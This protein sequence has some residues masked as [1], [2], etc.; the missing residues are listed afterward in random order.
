VWGL[1]YFD[2]STGESVLLA[3]VKESEG[4]LVGDNVV[5]YP[6]AFTDLSADIRYTYTR[7]GFEQDVVFRNNPPAPTE[8]GLN[9]ET[10]RLQVLTEFV[11]AGTPTK[12]RQQLGQL[13]DDTLGFSGLTIGPG[14][15]F[16]VPAG[17][18]GQER[19]VAKQWEQL[20]GRD[21]LIEELP[22]EEVADQLQKLPAA[23]KYEGASLRRRGK[24]DSA[25]AGLKALLPQRYAKVSPTPTGAPRRMAMGKY[26]PELGFVL[27]YVVTLTGQISSYTFRGDTTYY[28]SGSVAITGSSTVEGGTVLKYASG[29]QLMLV[30]PP[31]WQASAYR[32]VILT[33]KDD[34]SVGEKISG[35]TGN[36][37]GAYASCALAFGYSPTTISNFRISYAQTAITLNG[38]GNPAFSNG[39]LVNC[40]SGFYFPYGGV[41]LAIRN[42]LF[43]NVASGFNVGS[44]SS[45]DAQNTTFSGVSGLVT[46]TGYGSVNLKN[47]ILANVSTLTS[48]SGPYFTLSGTTNGFY[49]CQ[50]Y[51]TGTITNTFHPF[52]TVAAGS[53]YL[54][55]GC[56]FLNA[57][58]TN[59]A[60][61][62]L[63]SLNQKTT[64][65]PIL[66]SNV[67]C[68]PNLSLSP[69]A[70]RD[71]DAPDLGYHYEPLDYL[72]CNLT[73]DTGSQLTVASG[74]AVGSGNA[75]GIAL[76]A[77][78]SL[79]SVGT[80]QSPNWFV[81]YQAVQEQSLFWGSTTV[82][83][84][85]PVSATGSPSA[86]FQ[87]SKFACPVGGGGHLTHAGNA[88]F[89]SL[90]VQ[91]CE[92]WNGTNTVGGS[93]NSVTLL[94]NNLFWRSPLTANNPNPASTLALSNN[95][96]YGTTVSLSK[97]AG[98]VWYAF[99]NAFD[100]C[101][102]GGYLTNGYNAYLGCSGRLSPLNAQDV[103]RTTTLSYASSWL[104]NFYLP[105]NSPLLNVGSTTAGLAGLYH[106]TTQTNQTKEAAT[107]VDIGY[108][109]V[110]VNGSGA[111][112]DSDA[113]NVPDYVEDTNGNGSYEAGD[114][115]NWNFVDVDGNDVDDRSEDANGNGIP[116]GVEILMGF[117]PASANQLGNLTTPGYSL[118][119]AA[120]K[121]QTK[122]P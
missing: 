65:P 61:G 84:G 51:G 13:S 107:Q 115:S 7:S 66:Y 102:V 16:S 97:P 106:F 96:V 24:G 93:A 18:S 92:F 76:G 32:P 57:G 80:P 30:Y 14:K 33:A 119:L 73:C 103:V 3:E 109:Y 50:Q 27:D 99:N 100:T 48:V 118:W 31:V 98:V 89:G 117:N 21:F 47:C 101:T 29:A 77:G 54:S 71:T 35:S 63:A 74:T 17:K 110:A 10:T 52:Q 41:N 120:P 64:Q 19:P 4:Q 6:D 58:T 20:E 28:L 105:V 53:F 90:R 60:S 67:V 78:S 26:Q 81:R 9:P 49:Q 104:G 94:Q 75:S 12:T 5:V 62:L 56:N 70:Q 42:L 59:L 22:Y 37:S 46:S 112:V 83:A 25:L 34:D 11:E 87:F 55:P 108:H 45:V 23:A 72:T 121:P 40:T 111:P 114:L 82:S 69:Q 86:E 85:L 116:D 1:A 44:Y 8:F 88:A 68:A 36:P 39:Q 95:L 113:D 91:H 122:V 43:A 2:S 15:A 38:G 79:V